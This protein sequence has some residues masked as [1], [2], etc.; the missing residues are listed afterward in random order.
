MANNLIQIKR[1]GTNA[2]IPSLANGELAY[3][4]NG[5]ILYIGG[6]DGGGNV[7]IGG[8]QVP[9]ILTANQALV[10]NST[11]GI[12]K[13]I[14]A[15]AVL[16][17]IYANGSF[18]ANGYLLS[19]DG[20]NT[21]WVDPNT[22]STSASGSNTQI[23]FND[24]GAF[25]AEN[26]FTYNK[27][28]DTLGVV[29]VLISNTVN[30]TTIQTGTSFIAN[31]TQV[32]IA[33]P[34]NANNSHGS[35][36]QVLTSNG[37]GVYWQTLTADIT[38][39][40]AG[41]GLTGGGTEGD[42]TLSVVANNG[43]TANTS[44][45]FARGAN[46]ISVTQD[47][48]NVVAGHGIV[49][50]GNV[51]IQA[52]AGLIANTSGLF[53]DGANGIVVTAAGINVLGNTGVTSNTSGVFIGQPVATTDNVTFNDITI[54]GNTTLGS[55]SADVIDVKGE[56]SSNVLPSANITHNLGAITDRWNYVYAA[57]VHSDQGYFEG[58]VQVQ[59][60][61]IVQGNLV[62][63]NVSSLDVVD[64]LIY[65][66]SNNYASD[67]V[68]IGFVGNYYDGVNQRHA[69]LVRHAADDTFY[70]FHRYLTEPDDNII[71]VGN[72]SSDFTFATLRAFIDTGA[73]VANSQT[74]TITANSTLS[75][76]I[77][78][79]TL[80]LSTPLSGTDGGTGINSVTNN[81]LL[82]GNGSNGYT[83]LSLGTS[84]KV[85]QSDGTTVVYADLDG[86]TF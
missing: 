30:A 62:T 61:L 33:A 53:A 83:Q 24:S 35:S 72:S 45:V 50:D 38:S 69:G 10:A 47:G 57:N 39:V 31:G 4:S 27:D 48:I 65:L 14:A 46:G 74:V 6:P 42:L 32:T 68:D 76:D 67:L 21:F 15:N 22:L 51:A 7:R 85:L 17:K 20:G 44:G 84:G 78:A 19:S 73:F 86:G 81:A 11:G 49:V 79:N 28:T 23:Q 43:I 25:G 63:V 9:G 77:T 60:D 58:S 40:T 12:D 82:V 70:L 71:H 75:V 29:N 59:G 26:T 18:G 54:N 1:S 37:T 36:G 2:T 56:I 64:P 16:Q 5:N 80:T 55:S 13:V 41:N 8:Q 66:A 52:N 34:V 3:T